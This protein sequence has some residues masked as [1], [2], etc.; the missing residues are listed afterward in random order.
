MVVTA[1]YNVFVNGLF[2]GRGP[3]EYV[4]ELTS[5]RIDTWQAFGAEDVIEIKIAKINYA[6]A[7]R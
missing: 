3:I 1:Q 2:Y 5:D 4:H 7:I 6:E